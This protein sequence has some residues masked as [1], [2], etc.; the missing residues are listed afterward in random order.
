VTFGG[1][2]AKPLTVAADGSQVT[3]VVPPGAQSGTI[4]LTTPAGTGKKDGFKVLPK[5]KAAAQ[6][7]P[8]AT[9]PN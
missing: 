2:E 3:F 8:P 7:K 4:G 5:P 6:S 9:K 1:V